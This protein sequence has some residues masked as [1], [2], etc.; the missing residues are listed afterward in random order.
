MSKFYTDIEVRGNAIFHRY[1]EDGIRKKEK[2]TDFC[3]TLYIY[4]DR[5]VGIKDI[6]GT[7]VQPKQF[8][9]MS[10]AR[11]FMKNMKDVDG[12]SFYGSQDYGLL[13]AGETYPGELEY[14]LTKVRVGM[15]DIEVS[16]P[17]GEGFPHPTV[18]A[19]PINLITIH[20]SFTDTFFVFGEKP[21][22]PKQKNVKYLCEPDERERLLKFITFMMTLEFDVISGW[23]SNTFDIPYIF[24]RIENLFGEETA[25]KLSP[26]GRYEWKNLESEDLSPEIEISGIQLLDYLQ[27]YQKHVPGEK[28]SYKLDY[29]GELEL[30]LKKVSYEEEYG[31]IYN[32]AQKNWE[33]FVDYNI[34][35]VEI[36]LKLDRKKQLLAVQM[37][38]AYTAKINYVGAFGSV[39]LW[40]A[41]IHNDLAT[42]NQVLPPR[43]HNK[44]D[45]A[46]EGA[47]VKD[48]IVGFYRWLACFDFT[49]LYPTIMASYNI[50]P[51]SLVRSIYEIPHEIREMVQPFW[52][53][54]VTDDVCHG[55][56]PPEVT[57]ALRA[58][59]LCMTGNGELFW[60]DVDAVI[61]RLVR[62]MFANRRAAKKKMLELKKAFELDPTLLD[63]KEEAGVLSVREQ[64]Y[65]ICLNSLYGAFGSEWFCLFEVALAAAV[66][67]TGQGY[68]RYCERRFN[69][70][71]SGITGPRDY[72]VAIDTDSL[73]LNLGPLQEKFGLDQAALT[74]AIDTKLQDLAGQY[75][76]AV[77]NATGVTNSIMGL[78]REKIIS[79]AVFV[80]KKRYV[81][82]AVDNEGVVY[83]EPDFF[84][85]GLE[86]KRSSTPRVVRKSLEDVYKLILD[87]NE[88]GL[89]DYV[90]RFKL[91]YRTLP[92]EQIAYPSSVNDI[93]KWAN[94]K[95]GNPYLKGTPIHV[96][97]SIMHNHLIKTKGLDKN[98]QAIAEGSKIKYIYLDPKNPMREDV[99]GFSGTKIPSEFDLDRYIDFDLMFDKSFITPVKTICD[100]AGLKYEK[101]RDLS[102]FF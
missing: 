68:I 53:R 47:F 4:S 3:P 43:R 23:Y 51:E 61:P 82:Y 13:F 28:E 63:A 15:L 52:R 42:R 97:A 56:I 69:E 83:A 99:I 85:T 55:S 92:I 48:T 100:V 101:K 84:V 37:M 72:V 25:S 44:K 98:V 45:Q 35:D 18:A 27:L 62:K 75:I 49:S 57:A 1:V 14:D 66:T 50:S 11:N 102:S 71:L 8:G 9:S 90:S 30:K 12:M 95:A 64:A 73:Y 78:K 6:F 20:D 91:E 41:I 17:D 59:N 32:F 2:V 87:R 36:P 65:K 76:D 88:Q 46:Y 74:K 19:W 89:I 79:V 34:R 38:L 81:G 96:R 16:C 94:H 54:N 31:T 40:T 7:N 67:L 86:S 39:G 93:K 70:Y 22:T 77:V 5:D 10:D 24:K 29:I 80:K 60:T 58:H 33:L 26:W 21:Y